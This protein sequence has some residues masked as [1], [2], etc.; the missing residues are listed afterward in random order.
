MQ[1]MM[2]G[3]MGGAMA[4]YGSALPPPTM[5]A[6]V[7]MHNITRIVQVSGRITREERG[8]GKETVVM[9]LTKEFLI[10]SRVLT[11]IPSG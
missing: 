7:L 9:V 3:A 10:M 8:E 2:G 11:I 5:E 1:S 6:N 4:P